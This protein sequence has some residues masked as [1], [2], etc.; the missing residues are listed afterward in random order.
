MRSGPRKQ[1]GERVR[2]K[3]V[4]RRGDHLHGELLQKLARLDPARPTHYTHGD[5]QTRTEKSAGEGRAEYIGPPYAR[6]KA[7]VML[8]A[9]PVDYLSA[10]PYPHARGAGGDSFWGG[11]VG[12]ACIPVAVPAVT[13]VDG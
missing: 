2:P 6:I 8:V 11:L 7:H 3:T 4:R 13:F 9:D 10:S 5:C 1:S 12:H